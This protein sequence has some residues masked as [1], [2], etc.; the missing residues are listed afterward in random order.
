MTTSPR[1]DGNA[2]HYSYQPDAPHFIEQTVRVYLRLA[3]DGT[4]WIVDGATVGGHPLDSAYSD[5][6]ATNTECACDRPEECEDLRA[7]AD[8]IPLPTGPEVAQ[9]ILDASA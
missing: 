1:A 5:E 7:A 4:R 8:R 2:T 9:L 3:G 6:T